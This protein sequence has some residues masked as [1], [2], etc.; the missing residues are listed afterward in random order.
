[1]QK[2]R[3]DVPKSVNFSQLNPTLFSCYFDFSGSFFVCQVG[4]LAVWVARHM[5]ISAKILMIFVQ[6]VM[7]FVCKNLGLVRGLQKGF[8]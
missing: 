4:M 3:L 1:M 2:F 7:D 8:F 6:K 5:G